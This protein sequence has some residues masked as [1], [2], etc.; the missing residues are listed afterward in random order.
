M[1]SND[2][3]NTRAHIHVLTLKLN[4]NRSR[5][6]VLSTWCNISSRE[7]GQLQI[8]NVWLARTFIYLNTWYPLLG[9]LNCIIGND[10]YE[11]FTQTSWNSYDVA[12]R[13]GKCYFASKITLSLFYID[14]SCSSRPAMLLMEHFAQRTS[15]S[16]WGGTVIKALMCYYPRK[17]KTRLHTYRRKLVQIL[18]MV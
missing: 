4:Y 8:V 11:E 5:S 9:R 10:S 12:Y 7:P 14:Q 16:M 2:S 1:S 6:F 3:C 18:Q 15:G 13:T 17:S